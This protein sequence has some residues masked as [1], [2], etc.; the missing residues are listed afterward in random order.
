MADIL[1]M[2]GN[3]TT[4][5]ASRSEMILRAREQSERAKRVA[6]SGRQ[7][8]TN[9]DE[10]N[11]HRT[12]P[13]ARQGGNM[14]TVHEHVVPRNNGV[15]MEDETYV[16]CCVPRKGRAIGKLKRDGWKVLPDLPET[17]QHELI[18]DDYT[19]MLRDKAEVRREYR[20]SVRN[21]NG[22]VE[23]IGSEVFD[24]DDPAIDTY[25][26]DRGPGVSLDRLVS[27]L[28]DGPSEENQ[29]YM[30]PDNG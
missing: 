10:A 12:R 16:Y 14:R 3:Q 15:P 5:G 29:P 7:R 30:D 23:G 22:F 4:D 6:R 21:L 27:R 19:V 2:D 24:A 17:P 11:Q 9:S 13:N 28:P 26:L 1:T 18:D 20:N 8:P 25:A